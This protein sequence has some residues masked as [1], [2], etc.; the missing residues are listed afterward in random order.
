[1]SQLETAAII[2]QQFIKEEVGGKKINLV[3]MHLTM[4]QGRRIIKAA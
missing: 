2:F 3:L 4:T 1:M